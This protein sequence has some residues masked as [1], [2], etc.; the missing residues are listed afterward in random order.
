MERMVGWH[1]NGYYGLKGQ[2][3]GMTV[4]GSS[5]LTDARGCYRVESSHFGSCF[6]QAQFEN[7]ED[8]PGTLLLAGMG[9]SEN[10]RNFTANASVSPYPSRY[11][12]V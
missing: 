9:R 5:T 3:E 8:G 10:G 7:P 1:P 11:S 12:P 2:P 4:L 6:P